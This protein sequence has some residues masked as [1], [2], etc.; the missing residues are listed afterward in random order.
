MFYLYYLMCAKLKICVQNEPFVCKAG[1]CVQ[2]VCR[3]VQ[4]VC[5]QKRLC[6]SYNYL[7]INEK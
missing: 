6:A 5:S 1:A 4:N 2:S 7:I 3:F